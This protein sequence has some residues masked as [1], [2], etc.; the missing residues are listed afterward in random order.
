PVKKAAVKKAP[1][2]KPAVST[3]AVTETTA[4]DAAEKKSA[5]ETSA[6]AATGAVIAPVVVNELPVTTAAEMPAPVAQ[7]EPEI[8]VPDSAPDSSETL[9]DQPSSLFGD[10]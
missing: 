9:N 6:R 3:P 8:S 7:P 10:N 2:P 1:A 4:Q 5:V